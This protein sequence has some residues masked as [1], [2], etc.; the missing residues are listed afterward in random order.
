[1][2][3]SR[4]KR[5]RLIEDN[6]GL[7]H[8]C[9]R[10]FAD[11]GTEYD[12]LFQAGCIGLI[13]AADGF[14][15]ERGFAFSTYAV[16]AILGEI[17]RIFRDGGAIKV[18]RGLKEKARK[19]IKEKQALEEKLGREPTIS[20]LSE[21]LQTDDAETAFILNSSMPVISLTADEN[22]GGSQLDIPVQ[23]P[24]DELT[25]MLALRKS[26]S[27]LEEKDKALI[28]LRYFRGMTQSAAAEQLGMS[29]V[30]VSRREKVILS[31]IREMMT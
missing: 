3:D 31:S 2:V 1:V 23:S 5:E 27:M 6:L 14:D 21:A 13:K 19:A 22:S 8:S 15:E 12:D 26:I 20:E 7:V 28:E 24:E 10:K 9:A 11:K 25:D 4:T 18:G 29:Q 30:Q 17:K 16:P